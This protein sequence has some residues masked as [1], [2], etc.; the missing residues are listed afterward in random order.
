MPSLLA[1]VPV[2]EVLLDHQMSNILPS[3]ELNAVHKA[4]HAA[5]Y[6]AARAALRMEKLLEKNVTLRSADS[7]RLATIN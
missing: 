6:T 2:D 4:E 3:D 1:Q 5:A 7:D